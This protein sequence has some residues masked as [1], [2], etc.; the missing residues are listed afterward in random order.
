[1][2]ISLSFLTAAGLVSAASKRGLGWANSK[3]PQDMNHFNATGVVTW[4]YNWSPHPDDLSTSGVEFIPMQ[5]GAENIEKFSDAVA[6]TKAKAILAFNEPDSEFQ[7]N[8]NPQDAAAL[9]KEYIQPLKEFGVLLGAPA[10]TSSD[11][12]HI[13][14]QQ[15]FDA[16][17]GCKFDFL[18]LHWFGDGIGPFYDFI[19]SRNGEFKLPLWITEFASTSPDDAVVQDFLKQTIAYMDTLAFV[20]RYSWFGAFRQDGTNNDHYALLNASGNLTSLGETYLAKTAVSSSQQVPL[21]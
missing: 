15:F 11:N 1:M 2:K 20:E 21:Q 4:A 19:W 14:L 6:S 8:L 17:I 5:W 18:P 9:W 16:C 12:G 7:S 13:W 3:N 10:V